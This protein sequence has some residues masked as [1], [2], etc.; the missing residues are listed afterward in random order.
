[1]FNR[2]RISLE[3]RGENEGAFVILDFFV[4]RA[5]LERLQEVFEN[6]LMSEKDFYRYG[7]FKR[8]FMYSIGDMDAIQVFLGSDL[9]DQYF[10][11]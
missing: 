2:G 11:D 8:N 7:P 6:F 10:E 9:E 3:N 5:E 4:D 1:M